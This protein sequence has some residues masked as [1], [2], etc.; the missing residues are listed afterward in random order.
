MAAPFIKDFHVVR[1]IPQ[2]QIDAVTNKD[3]FAQNI[4]YQ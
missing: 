3:E 4:G 1:P 2:K